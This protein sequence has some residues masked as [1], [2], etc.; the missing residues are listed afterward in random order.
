MLSEG[1]SVGA[2]RNW[3]SIYVYTVVGKQNTDVHTIYTDRTYC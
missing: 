1:K 2:E 3:F